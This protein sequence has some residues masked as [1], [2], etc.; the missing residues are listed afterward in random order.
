M[1]RQGPGRGRGRRARRR[2]PERSWAICSSYRR[3]SAIAD[4]RKVV[5]RAGPE[6]EGFSPE[7]EEESP[8]G[9][10]IVVFEYGLEVGLVVAVGAGPGAVVVE[11]PDASVSQNAPT[12]PAVGLD[13]GGRK[14]A[15]DL[16]VGRAG[17][18][19]VRLRRID[20]DPVAAVAG[21]ERQVEAFA[22]LDDGGVPG[23]R[24]FRIGPAGGA[25]S[26]IRRR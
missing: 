24:S 25:G 16:A 21:I 23:S 12:N 7:E 8:Q 4:S 15:E 9:I 13:V 5:G 17:S 6:G 14:V 10:G 22:L 26:W 11:S 20:L 19:C 3:P 1:R 2:R 18:P